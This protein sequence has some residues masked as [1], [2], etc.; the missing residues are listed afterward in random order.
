MK[1]KIRNNLRKEC[2]RFKFSFID[3]LG[4]YL[5]IIFWGF[6]F[7]GPLLIG[8]YIVPGI[9]ALWV[10]FLFNKRRWIR[11]FCK[12]YIEIFHIRKYRH[13]ISYDCVTKVVFEEPPFAE[14][15]LQVFYKET[16]DKIIRAQF[17][18]K[19]STY[20]VEVL[21]FIKDRLPENVIDNKSLIYANIL[22]EEE[23]YRYKR[24]TAR[25]YRQGKLEW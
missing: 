4:I 20:L 2:Y 7:F 12:D 22:F 21:N 9:V 25:K 18:Q 6:M 8:Y 14:G 19:N 1:T 11:Y 16:N 15:L 23:E 5:S 3:Q 10:F 13:R 24:G 17:E